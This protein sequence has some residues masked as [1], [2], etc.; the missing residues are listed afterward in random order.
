[1]SPIAIKH[2]SQINVLLHPQMQGLFAA[3][4]QA[5]APFPEARAAVAGMLAGDEP[6]LE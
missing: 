6:K 4:L 5:L 3:I 2:N 1:V